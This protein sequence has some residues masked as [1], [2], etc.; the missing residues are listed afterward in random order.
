MSSLGVKLRGL[1]ATFALAAFVFG[2]PVLLVYMRSL[3]DLSVFSWDRLK[4]RDDG[5]L[6]LAV[7]YLGCWVSWAIFAFSVLLSLVSAVRGVR[8]PRLPGL[9]LP[10]GAANQL[11]ASAALL[12]ISV[13]VAAHTV[14]VPPAD[15]YA[16]PQPTTRLLDDTAAPTPETSPAPPPA[17]PEPAP[18]EPATAGTKQTETNTYT[19]KRGDSLWRIA[20]R[21]L[22]SGERFKEI[23]ALNVHVLEQD[24]D[25][26]EPGLVLRLPATTEPGSTE[27][28]EETYVVKAG[29][30]LSDIAADELGDATR[31]PQIFEASTDT[32][33]PDGSRLSDPDLIRPGWTLTI[34]DTEKTQVRGGVSE[35]S[36][37]IPPAQT[38]PSTPR[39]PTSATPTSPSTSPTPAAPTVDL[40]ET[41]ADDHNDGAIVPAW[42]LPGLTGSGAVLAGLLLLALRT[43]RRTGLRNRR[44]GH[45]LAEPPDIAN[46]AK[47]ARFAGSVTAPDIL[48]LNHL[49]ESLDDRV[50][51]L[52][53]L[54]YV[55]LGHRSATLH[56]ADEASLPSPWTGAGTT[57]TAPL[58][59]DP[60]EPTYAC[61]YP[62]LVG[63]GEHSDRGQCL[64]NL[65]ERPYI[66]ITGDPERRA[67]FARYVSAEL[68]LNPWSMLVAVDTIGEPA[69]VTFRAGNLDS[70]NEGRSN[71]HHDEQ[72]TAFAAAIERDL[73][74]DS[75]SWDPELLHAV[76][77]TDDHAALV[78]RL[79]E[80]IT[81]YPARC[82]T[83]VVLIA[84]EPAPNSTTVE[85][86]AEGR[87]H[88][89]ALDLDIDAAGISESESAACAAVFALSPVPDNVRFPATDGA[90]DEAGAIR[91]EMTEARPDV[92]PAGP[93][94]ML[95]KETDAYVRAAA[96]TREDVEALAPV[97]RPAAALA[98][99]HDPNLD[100]E[101]DA[102]FAPDCAAPR[103][104]LLGP[105]TARTHGDAMAI[106]RRKPFYVEL[107]TYLVLHPEGVPGAQISEDFGLQ[108]A[109]L[110]TDLG[111]VRKWLGT[112]PATGQLHLP[113]A[114]TSEV[115]GARG[116]AVYR[117]DGVMTDWDL[118][119]RLRTRAQLRG[120]DGMSDLIT[121][122][123]LVTGEPFSHR[124]PAGW[125]WLDDLRLTDIAQCAIVD[126]AHVV[127]AHALE[128]HDTNLA[129]VTVEI[130]CKASPY[131][132]VCRLDLARVQEATGNGAE[133]AALLDDKVFNR[134]DDHL[135]PLATPDRTTR[136]ADANGWPGKSAERPVRG[137]T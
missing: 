4:A 65:E 18:A 114:A 111:N 129:L 83:A 42:V 44:P 59:A 7:I 52:P 120:A 95:P 93:R 105:V 48:G 74:P 91:E 130:A 57:W 5:T 58:P 26:L 62:L 73:D 66:T 1:A 125:A 8:A 90:T 29:D 81:A 75:A 96:T 85:I 31:Y 133:A 33:Q 79:A 3:P 41:P 88:L 98:A 40:G 104:T 76:I 34:P 102:W 60:P 126:T 10:Q 20:E 64:I 27:A 43:H 25:Y 19:V 16:P 122:L 89:P 24:P 137:E 134:T 108:I 9:A 77:A 100:A 72:D 115:S 118:F 68:S 69:Q 38:P 101:V 86:T 14:A 136:V 119:K 80:A 132:E 51:P 103:L 82:G 106:A 28:T 116:S 78:H 45:I 53:R 11:V 46:V 87:L 37:P 63:I 110:R 22:G 21:H 99:E 71:H 55:D 107:L 17:R 39:G 135:G 124:R 113:K 123:D 56:L 50:S 15:A 54:D 23:A 2:V 13:P 131:D 94:S 117:V 70:F 36:L 30:T 61:P 67:A 112:N 35:P 84:D 97:T 92:E 12:F 128:A 109:R 121:A 6:A 32:E 127:T 47:T 49:L